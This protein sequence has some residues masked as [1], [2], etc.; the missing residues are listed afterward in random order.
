MKDCINLLYFGDFH[1]SDK[2]PNSRI[3]DY[4]QTEKKKIKEVLSIARKYNCKAILQP[5]DFLDRPKLPEKFLKEILKAFEYTPEIELRK[6]L[7]SGEITEQEFTDRL[8]KNIP[9]VGTV[10]N[11]EL[12][13]GSL[14]SYKST[15]L[16]F[17]EEIGFISIVDQEKSY[18]LISNGNKISISGVPFDIKNIKDKNNFILNSKKGDV[19][20]LL[21]HDNIYDKPFIETEIDWCSVSDISKKTKADITIS[22]HIHNGFG[23]L[24]ENNKIFG[25]PGVLAQ[26][27]SSQSELNRP[28]TVSII[29]IDKDKKITIKD[30]ELTTPRS[31]DLFDF[32]LKERKLTE[33]EQLQKIEEI[34]SKTPKISSSKAED[35][36]TELAT[37]EN[38]EESILQ[39]ALETTIE[40]KSEFKDIPEFDKNI[41]Y[42]IKKI[43]LENFESHLYTEIDITKED[44]TVIIGESSQGKSSIF[45]AAFWLL[46]NEGDAKNFLRKAPGVDTVKVSLVR[47]DNLI[48]TRI[49]S[50]EKKKNRIKDKILK[51]GYI[52]K[53]PSGEEFETNTQGLSKVQELFAFYKLQLS[54]KEQLALN[55]R[56]Q[57]DGRYFIGN[58]E[59]ARAKIIGSLYG[60]Q[61]IIEAGRKL[62]NEKSNNDKELKVVEK[63]INE[64]K[65][66]LDEY[67][68]IDNEKKELGRLNKVN[69]KKI[70]I[71]KR[72]ADISALLPEYEQD[73]FNIIRLGNFIKSKDILD[74]LSKKMILAKENSLKFD[75]IN[76]Y[77]KEFEESKRSIEEY[78]KLLL[79]KKIL[80]D[81]N[82]K[83]NRFRIKDKNILDLDKLIIAFET[84]KKENDLYNILLENKHYQN[85]LAVKF[86]KLLL[87]KEKREKLKEEITAFSELSEE[88]LNSKKIIDEFYKKLTE[89]K[90]EHKLLIESEDFSNI[91]VGKITFYNIKVKGLDEGNKMKLEELEKKITDYTELFNNAEKKHSAL[92][93][94]EK[95][96]NEM[97]ENLGVTAETAKEELAKLNEEQRELQ[98][99][100]LNSL[101]ILDK[102][103]KEF[104]ESKN[105]ENSKE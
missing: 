71:E 53:L 100:I 24:T 57:E 12:Y 79:H 67:K 4:W 81:L 31:K 26:Q 17:L 43:I 19:D 20:I 16:S 75:K 65:S 69:I 52:I 11:H 105:S 8:L 13:G 56:K 28:I 78:E 55:F 84:D 2:S 10:G 64:L 89:L 5:G 99:D 1:L 49:Y 38:F 48:C 60:T 96:K 76:S 98:N 15:S 77:I 50:V 72:I 94:R 44:C 40:S 97:F 27:S 35:I 54:P 80:V 103:Y 46:E 47:S 62:G 36:I 91:K 92:K 63:D 61:Y 23:W 73:H 90:K 3:D 18:D 33:S 68:L 30:I 102:A 95:M 14:K 42:S 88:L 83:I 93:E 87:L 104:K 37:L 39:K 85:N 22:G 32:S 74:T 34:L 21:L 70:S 45:R 59:N 58:S 6:L 66:K 51:N 41:D 86:K 101:D 7:D 9:L 82:E 25:N 29:S